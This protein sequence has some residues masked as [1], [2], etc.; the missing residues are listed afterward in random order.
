MDYRC[1]PPPPPLSAGGPR[2]RRRRRDAAAAAAAASAS[3]YIECKK[4]GEEGA[5]GNIR[6]ICLPTIQQRLSP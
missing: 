6:G 4:E 2:V 3:P 1:Y 5:T